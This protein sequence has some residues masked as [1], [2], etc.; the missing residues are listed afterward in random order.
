VQQRL[1]LGENAFIEEK[2]HSYDNSCESFL[3]VVFEV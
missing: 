2:L 3:L 1:S